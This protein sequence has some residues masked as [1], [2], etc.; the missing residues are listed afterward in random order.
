MKTIR[1]TVNRVNRYNNNNKT[2]S[3]K[4]K[5]NP[6]EPKSKD[7]VRI[8]TITATFL[9]MLNIVKLHWNTHVFAASG[10][11]RTVFEFE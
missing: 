6:T 1:K 10:D 8:S 4:Y 7:G 11:R 9:E 2:N 5:I 3:I